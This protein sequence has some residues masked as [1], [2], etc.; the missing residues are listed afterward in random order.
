[1]FGMGT[2][3]SLVLWAPILVFVPAGLPTSQARCTA[4][5]PA[6]RGVDVR[7][8]PHSPYV[9]YD[10]LS[11]SLSPCASSGHKTQNERVT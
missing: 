10:S 1:M 4:S 11:G 3:V 7:S 2:G 6:N 5:L 8:P 9:E